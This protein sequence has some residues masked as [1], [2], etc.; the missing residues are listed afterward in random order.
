VFTGPAEIALDAG[1]D[2]GD[3]GVDADVARVEHR[4]R[5]RGGQLLHVLHQPLAL[6]GEHQ[7]HPR[8]RQRLRDGPGD[9]ALVSDAEDDPGLAVEHG[10]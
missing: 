9:R 3:L 7:P 6:V 1:E 8:A 10:P 4:A 5:Q 2:R